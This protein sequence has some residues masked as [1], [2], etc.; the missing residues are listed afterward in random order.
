[1]VDIHCHILPGLDDGSQSFEESV[2]MAKMANLGGTCVIIATPHS[3]VTDSYQNHWTGAM[4][5][6]ISDINRRLEQEEVEL[7][8]CPGQEIFADGDFLELLRTERLITLNN[9]IYPL[10]EFGF[11]DRSYDVYEKLERL[12]AEGFVPIVAHPERYAFVEGDEDAISRIKRIGC[13]IQVNKG[14]IKGSF[15]INAQRAAERI[16]RYGKADFIA[17]DA[18]GPFLRTPDLS[19]VYETVCEH[20]SA[21]YAKLLMVKNPIRVIKNKQIK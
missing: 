5:R 21:D 3:N 13:L 16:L 4:L 20:Y 14:S 19:D 11:Y 17:S 2:R 9:S 7:R 18:H 12:V 15:G 8:V 10:V 1:M 6:C